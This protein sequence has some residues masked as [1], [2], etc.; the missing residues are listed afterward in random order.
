MKK[1]NFILG[2]L[3]LFCCS[4]FAQN[5]FT[6]TSTELGG[7]ATTQEEFNGF[8]CT[9][10][11]QSPR[12]SWKNA[13]EGTKSFAITMYD[14]DAP[15]GSGWWHWVVFDIPSNTKELV[16]GAGN[17]SLNLMPKGS[18]QSLTDYGTPGYGGPCPPEG[19]GLH[20]YVITVYAL[21]TEKL[22]LTA[23]TNP[24]V[25]GYYLWNNTLAKASIVTYYQRFSK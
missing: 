12:L 18:I 24:A 6:L 14:P 16:T 3:F 8:G 15:T 19:H 9:G 21:K 13:P 23:T 11:N 4:A 22:G 25:V 2:L 20:Q 5:T 1:S 7:E 10:K 17:T